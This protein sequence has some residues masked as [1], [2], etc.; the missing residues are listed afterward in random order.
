[1]I[2]NSIIIIAVIFLTTVFRLF[3]NVTR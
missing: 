2:D 1:M 3:P